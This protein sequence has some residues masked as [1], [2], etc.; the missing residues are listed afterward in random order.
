MDKKVNYYKVELHSINREEDYHEIKGKL[1]DII[2]SNSDENSGLHII[3]LNDE[4]GLHVIADIFDYDKEYLFMR[5]SGQ[6]P[7]GSYIQ[8]DYKNNIPK[9]VFDGKSEEERGIESY[10]YAFLKYETG[11]LEI[12][13]QK[14]APNYKKINDLFTKYS[15]NYYLKFRPIPNSNGID[16]IYGKKESSIS[17]IEIEVPVPNADA[18]ERIFGWKQ[19]EILDILD[20]QEDSLKAV[21]ELSGIDRKKIT[22]DSEK[23][24]KL[25]DVVKGTITNGV[26]KAKL[27]GK[28]NGKKMQDY[29]F[30]DENFT[31]PVSINTYKISDGRKVYLTA[32]ELIIQYKSNLEM[33]YIENE[34]LLKMI[35]DRNGE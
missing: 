24:D 20:F 33:A 15:D 30:F 10:T 18:L 9:A 4:D 3:E 32:Q 21:L 35:S 8:R 26:R 29:S 34:D 27:R 16:L 14:G 22:D 19:K 13:N 28:I 1:I 25:I 23:T 11:I 17:R 12:V 31:Y 6:K 2:N 7:T 5:L